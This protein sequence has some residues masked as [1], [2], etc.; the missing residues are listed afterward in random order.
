MTPKGKRATDAN[1]NIDG[2]AYRRPSCSPFG[3]E[4]MTTPNIIFIFSDQQR[5]DT[6]GCY[7]QPLEVTPNLDRL[8]AEGVRFENAFTC[9]P[10]CGPARACIQTGK[11]ATDLGCHV[12]HRMLPVNERTIAHHL[13]E[14]GYE[15]G[16]IGKW[17]LASCGPE[18]GSDDFRTKPVPPERRGGY[19]YWL[20]SDVLE[21]TSHGYDGHM[22][23]GEGNR[24]EFPEGRYRADAQTDWVV[25]Y[26]NSRSNEKPFF[27]FASYIEPHHQNDHGH[28][29]GPKGSKEKFKECAVPGDLV[30]T[31]GNWREEYADYLGCIRSLDENVG[32][33]RNTLQELGQEENTLLIYTSDHGSHFCTRNS[34]YKRSCHDGCIRIPLIIN[35]PGFKGNKCPQE[36]T[37]LIDL[38]PTIMTSAGITPPDAMRG[39]ALQRL[40][41]DQTAEWPQEVFLQ[42]SESQCGRAIRTRRWKYSVRAPDKSGNDP[43]SDVYVEDFLYDLESDPHERNN[44]VADPDFREIRKELAGTLKRRM[45]EAGEEEPEIRESTKEDSEQPD[46]AVTQETAPS[47]AP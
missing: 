24:R 32:R 33:I 14:H 12:N 47:A 22:F 45:V 36:L 7:G 43:S 9:Q 23:D 35:G 41:T 18:D 44:L 3:D 42:I 28:Y 34:E 30:D 10:V 16:Y 20:A 26:L 46:G 39:N 11:Y 37:S 6:C 13:S 29:E 17:H 31:G 15:T 1:Q 5:W 40:L 8:A 38:P 4:R 2:T 27:L 25:E 21:F 19:D